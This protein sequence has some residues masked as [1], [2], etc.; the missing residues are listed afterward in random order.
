MSELPQIAAAFD[1]GRVVLKRP[2]EAIAAIELRRHDVLT[3]RDCIMAILP[4]LTIC[5]PHL[6]NADEPA[7]AAF[8]EYLARPPCIVRMIYSE[9][10]CSNTLSR[11]LHAGYCGD[12]FFVRH[13]VGAE[14]IDLP[15]ST[16]NQNRSPLYVGRLGD[17]R[18]QIAGYQ[19]NLSLQPNLKNQ[20]S[21][22]RMSDG[23]QVMVGGIVCLGSQ[24]V[25]PGSFVWSG[26]KFK[27]QASVLAKQFGFDEFEGEIAVE[28]GVVKKMTVNGSGAWLYSYNSGSNL[29]FGV[30][31]ELVKL[32]ANE[33]C[34]DKVQIREMVIGDIS[35]Q[36]SV[37]DPKTH[38]VPEVT[39]ENVYSNSLQIIKPVE[40]AIV[41]EMLLKENEALRKNARRG[42]LAKRIVTLGAVLVVSLVFGGILMRKA[43]HKVKS[44]T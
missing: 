43:K 18:W 23:M 24:H 32:G 34:V 22:T 40:N 2:P 4:F 8:K 17:T 20:D 36:M 19:M 28:S 39:I 15:I 30:P 13:L 27:A 37:F 9:M 21:Y 12:S 44:V 1:N 3:T 6:S 16:N 38:I 10:S 26:N 41:M 42:S 11:S 29:P 35:Q 25:Q 14:N 7:V 5:V 31:S 33:L